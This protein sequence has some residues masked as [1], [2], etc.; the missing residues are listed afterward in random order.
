MSDYVNR[1]DVRQAL[2]IPD[3]LPGWNNCDDFVSENYN[4]Q[5]EASMWIYKILKQYGYKILFFSGDTDGAVPTYGSRRWLEILNW[6]VKEAWRSW[7]TDGQVSGY[8]IKYDGM[9]FAT[10]HGVGHMA[11]QWKRKDVTSLFTNWIHD[12]PI[13]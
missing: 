6:D 4:Y 13:E 7:H 3:T 10:I 1:A 9:D 11:P 2:N 12:L 5:Y 8:I